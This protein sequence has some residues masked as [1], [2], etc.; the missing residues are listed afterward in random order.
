MEVEYKQAT[1]LVN[2]SITDEQPLVTNTK[3][4][5]NISSQCYSENVVS[6][7]ESGVVQLGLACSDVLCRFP[8]HSHNK[9]LLVSL[10]ASSMD[11]KELAKFLVNENC[12][13]NSALH[14]VNNCKKIGLEDNT[15]LNQTYPSNVKRKKRNQKS[16][17]VLSNFFLNYCHPQNNPNGTVLARNETQKELFAK[18]KMLNESTGIGYKSYIYVS[19]LLH[20]LKSK[21][22]DFDLFYCPKCHQHGKGVKPIRPTNENENDL[23]EY[24]KQLEIEQHQMFVKIQ[25]MKYKNQLNNLRHEDLLIVQDISKHF[26]QNKKSIIHIFVVFRRIYGNVC[27]NSISFCSTKS[28][29]AQVYL[30]WFG[31]YKLGL[32]SSIKTVYVWQDGGAIDYFNSTMIFLFSSFETLFSIKLFVHFFEFCHGKSIADSISG[33]A[34]RKGSRLLKFLKIGIEYSWEYWA[35]VHDSIDKSEAYILPPT[36]EIGIEAKTIKGITTFRDFEFTGKVGEVVMNCPFSLVEPVHA[37]IKLQERK[38]K[39]KPQKMKTEKDKKE[40]K[41]IKL[42]NYIYGPKQCRKYFLGEG[43][44]LEIISEN[45]HQSYYLESKKLKEND[46]I[47]AK[48]DDTWYHGKIINFTDKNLK[49]HFSDDDSTRTLCSELLICKC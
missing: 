21:H 18:F 30:S 20:V 25:Q 43:Y 16:I 19:S 29:H 22:G 37:T 14:Y 26:T 34:T 17:E 31:L 1:V 7:K 44:H 23:L 12:N 3:D 42:T 48:F 41:R 45:G 32:F 10:L 39:K 11:S 28:G 49:V 40:R 2:S 47:L 15:L 9:Q 4:I 38:E 6:I 13:F 46:W 5:K 27:W 24:N 36:E 8:E 35:S 33:V